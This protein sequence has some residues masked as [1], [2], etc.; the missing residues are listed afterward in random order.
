[1]TRGSWTVA[2][3]IAIAIQACHGGP[4]PEPAAALPHA[5]GASVTDPSLVAEPGTGSL[6]ASW[7]AGD[8]TAWHLYFARS[9]DDGV[10]WSVP[11]RITT[12]DDD[13]MPHGEAS[14]R[15]VAATDGRL[16][17]VWPRSI[18][19]A[20][21]QWPATAIRLARST[22]GGR[23]WLPPV[24]LNDDTTSHPAGH[25]FHGAAWVGSAGLVAAWLDE[26][27]GDSVTSHE[28]HET[29]GEPTSEP[30]AVVYAAYS[31]DFGQTWEPNRPLWGA[32]CPC[33]CSTSRTPRAA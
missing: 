24:T 30:D 27:H 18:P 9:A 2:A 29:A 1:M 33:C 28:M 10:S 3:T 8:S 16:A 25:N 15:L 26:R 32:A 21:R 23:T 19:V 12:D 5:A 20:G 17:V 22:D 7:V 13:V 6:L 14:P 4:S 31:P 11:V